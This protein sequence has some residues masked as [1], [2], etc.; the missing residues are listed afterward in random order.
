MSETVN[1]QLLESLQECLAEFTSV[2]GSL[3]SEQ[4]DAVALH[5]VRSAW[6]TYY[7]GPFGRLDRL[8]REDMERGGARYRNLLPV[9]I[10]SHNLHRLFEV[11]TL[12]IGEGVL[13]NSRI[14]ERI[15]DLYQHCAGLQ[16][17]LHESRE[18]LLHGSCRSQMAIER[19]DPKSQY[20]E[21]TK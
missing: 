3:K 19:E 13:G 20:T 9:S 6:D 2:T 12:D 5:V 17:L 4:Q 1:E 18:K 10:S 15:E 16:K 8:L 14:P 7:F 21:A 11:L